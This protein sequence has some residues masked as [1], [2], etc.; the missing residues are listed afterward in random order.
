MALTYGF[1]KCKV[2]SEPTLKGSRQKH[3]IQ[4]HLHTQLEVLDAEG[5]PRD[6]DVAI[7]VG[8]ND[9]DVRDSLTNQNLLDGAHLPLADHPCWL[10]PG[11]DVR[12]WCY[13]TGHLRRL[14]ASKKIS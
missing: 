11:N 13:R 2:L 4:Y 8:T 1:A 7:N 3:E 14:A 9:A 6:W 5:H 12:C 10:V